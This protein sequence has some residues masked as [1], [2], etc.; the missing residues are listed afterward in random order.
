METGKCDTVCPGTVLYCRQKYLSH[1]KNSHIATGTQ[2]LL[3]TERNGVTSTHRK[4][5]QA[6][7]LPHTSL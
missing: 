4:G 2:T 7:A 1:L 5:V 6:V 3:N